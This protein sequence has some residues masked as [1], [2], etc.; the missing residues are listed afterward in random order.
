MGKEQPTPTTRQS[1]ELLMEQLSKLG[2]DKIAS[3]DIPERAKRA[4]LAEAIEDRIFG[5]TEDLKRIVDENNG[6]LPVT[7]VDREKS[8]QIAQQTKALQLQY[9]ELVKG[10]PSSLMQSLES[11]KSSSS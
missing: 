11:L 6:N 4:L 3:L 5:L 2:A 7:E 8:L 10:E 1:Q 9:E